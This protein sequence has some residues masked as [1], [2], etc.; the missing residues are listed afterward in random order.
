MKRKRPPELLEPK[1]LQVKER[2][3]NDL[4][5]GVYAPGSKLPP[6]SEL[7]KR[8]KVHRLTVVRA[9]N[10]LTQEGLI[11]RRRGSGTFVADRNSAPPL[12]PGRS[13]K[14]GIIWRRSV[15]PQLMLNSFLGLATYGAL[16]LAGI[17]P[18]NAAWALVRDHEPTCARW[19]DRHSRIQVECVGEAIT[20]QLR[21]PPLE[22]LRSR[23]FDGVLA[24]GILE[25][26]FLDGLLELGI[27]VVLC[28]VLK[29]RLN[30]K[31]DQVYV[32]PLDGYQ[33]AV[34]HFLQLGLKRIHF[35]AAQIS[36]PAP[37][38]GMSV[39]EILAHHGN[40]VRV[41]PDSYLRL[42]AYRQAMDAYGAE[43]SESFIHKLNGVNEW[44]NDLAA[45][46][47]ALP[48]SE[49]PEAV[50]CHESI[51]ADMLI[52]EFEKRGLPLLGAGAASTTVSAKA[53]AIRVDMKAVG[54]TAMDLLLSRVQRPRKPCLRVGVPMLFEHLPAP[55]VAGLGM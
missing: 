36:L 8:F 44:E 24:L 34:R 42:S 31:I 27:P 32:D 54:A 7:Y 22:C 20:S 14:I 55:A 16:E 9:M 33:K 15:Y 2:L 17:D 13:M 23:G 3:R 30:G 21:H 47:A 45:R 37:R 10:D 52:G 41:D 18:E 11:V 51:Q 49:R 25:D 5:C 48:E 28:D 35:V 26:S 43:V 6:D 39:H 38:T 46:L 40:R 19:A 1:Y 4:L 50:V 29:E 12:I 53:S